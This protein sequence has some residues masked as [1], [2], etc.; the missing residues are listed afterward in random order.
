MKK[1]SVTGKMK[2][3]EARQQSTMTSLFINTQILKFKSQLMF[4]FFA[5]VNHLSRP[6]R[7]QKFTST[8]PKGHDCDRWI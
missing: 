1:K 8:S 4:A 3:N 6:P 5:A 2:I 7:K